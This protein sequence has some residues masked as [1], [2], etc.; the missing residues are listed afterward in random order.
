M[1]GLLV[2]A[3]CFLAYSNGA[4]D[5]F[6]GVASLLGSKTASYRVSIAWATIT[7]FAGSL[8]AILL[9]QS[10]LAKFSGKGLVPEEL[11][12]SEH[13]VLAVAMGTGATVILATWLGFPIS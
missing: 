11:A 2:L 8:A 4:N 6:K 5:N 9:A 1:T 13:F 10:L 12:G 3:V 7:T